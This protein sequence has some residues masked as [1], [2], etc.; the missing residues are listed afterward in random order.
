MDEPP[1]LDTDLARGVSVLT[2]YASRFS[3]F[4]LSLICRE[5]FLFW[6]EEAGLPME[7]YD[8]E[9]RFVVIQFVEFGG[10]HLDR[11]LAFDQSTEGVN[12]NGMISLA[13]GCNF[14]AHC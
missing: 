1:F 12:N 3:I 9:T 7:E 14:L 11:I 10:D 6:L 2:L 8:R 13:P 5:S 4:D